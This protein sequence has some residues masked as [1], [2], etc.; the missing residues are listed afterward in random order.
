[1]T[2]EFK[3]LPIMVTGYPVG[4]NAQLI[5]KTCIPFPC[6]NCKNYIRE[7]FILNDMFLIN[8]D[9]N[10]T[11]YNNDGCEVDPGFTKIVYDEN[12]KATCPKYKKIMQ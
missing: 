7:H 5:P 9:T 2:L 10:P 11:Q 3:F 6:F 4:T 8:I 12:G 1:M